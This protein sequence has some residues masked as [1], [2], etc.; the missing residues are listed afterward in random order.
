MWDTMVDVPSLFDSHQIS[1]F[2]FK[3]HGFRH[4]IVNNGIWIYGH[5]FMSLMHR[6]YVRWYVISGLLLYGIH[7]FNMFIELTHI[8][9]ISIILKKLPCYCCKK[10][11]ESRALS[12][13]ARLLS[14]NCIP[15]SLPYNSTLSRNWHQTFQKS[16]I[17]SLLI[18]EDYAKQLMNASKR[19]FASITSWV[20]ICENFCLST[21]ARSLSSMKNL[22]L[23]VSLEYDHTI[24]RV[25]ITKKA[26]NLYSRGSYRSRQSW[27]IIPRKNWSQPST[28]SLHYLASFFQ[29]CNEPAM[30]DKSIATLVWV[31]VIHMCCLWYQYKFY[32][33]QFGLSSST[34]CKLNEL[35]DAWVTSWNT[36]SLES[37]RILTK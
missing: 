22:L 9:I 31:H 35:L 4:T 8:L 16:Y 17:F 3:W 21:Y 5:Q 24:L 32:G 10:L 28:S 34:K 18:C 23:W 33:H 19:M 14:C 29:P 7:S 12:P 11:K 25:T 6:D 37:Y 1:D 26:R 20:D 13:T 27:T 36:V 30:H 15:S 2:T